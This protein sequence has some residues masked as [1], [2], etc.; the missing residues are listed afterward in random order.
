VC[1]VDRCPEPYEDW[2]DGWLV[3][4]FGAPLGN[5]I[6]LC[7]DEVSK[8]ELEAAWPGVE[9]RVVPAPAVATRFD[10]DR[11]R[12]REM[13]GI[14]PGDLVVL[15]IGD[16]PEADSLRFS[17]LLGL[18]DVAGRSIV[19]VLPASAAHRGRGARLRR[20]STRPLRV[21][22]TN[23]PMLKVA[24]ACDMAV[25]DAGGD[26]PVAHR[27]PDAG[28]GAVALASVLGTGVPAVA[29]RCATFEAL[30]PEAARERCLAMNSSLPE[31]A[32]VLMGLADDEPGRAE[33]GR[34]AGARAAGRNA[35]E[36][37]VQ[38]VSD[39]WE[40]VVR[41]A[42]HTVAATANPATWGYAP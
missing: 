21:V 15:L 38:V 7:Y 5:A 3:D 33:M 35:A 30:Y 16:G 26:G 24:P 8:G 40:R 25:W 10:A 27:D 29:P 23:R 4:W 28:A 32:R 22:T 14:D 2:K 20:R 42:S 11:A 13:L 31:L 6:L 18:M 37:F 19:G 41:S 17:F 34:L 12:A 36:A 39:A 9:V 1:A